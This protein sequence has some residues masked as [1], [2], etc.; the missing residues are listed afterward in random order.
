MRGSGIRPDAATDRLGRCHRNAALS[1]ARADGTGFRGE[2]ATMTACPHAYLGIWRPC[3]FE[4]CH[5]ERPDGSRVYVR[6]VCVVCGEPVERT[7]PAKPSR[8]S[9]TGATP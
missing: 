8:T 7:P 4:A 5:D 2:A 6:H 1:S 9:R 3:E